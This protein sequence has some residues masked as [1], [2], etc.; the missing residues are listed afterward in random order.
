M[1]PNTA[2]QQELAVLAEKKAR[3]DRQRGQAALIEDMG[4][5]VKPTFWQRAKTLLRLRRA[6]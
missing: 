3:I 2:L 5:I 1:K 6:R 4:L